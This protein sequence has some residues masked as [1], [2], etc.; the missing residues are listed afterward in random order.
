[1]IKVPTTRDNLSALFNQTTNLY[2]YRRFPDFKAVYQFIFTEENCN[3]YY[4][5]KFAEGKAEYQEGTYES[6]SITIY[7]PVYVWYDICNGRLNGV[8]GWFTRK[9]R[10][11]GSFY[12][13]KILNKLLGKKFTSEDIQGIEDKIAGFEMNNGKGW[14]KPDKILI[15]NGSPRKKDGFTF[16][17]LQYLI[18]GIRKAGVSVETV[19]IYDN[20]LQIEPC[21]GCFSC[22]VKTKGN[23]I[24]KDDANELVQKIKDSYLTIFAFPL[25]IDSMPGKLKLLM[26]RLF[27][28]VKPV[29]V[30]YKKLTRH[31]LWSCQENYFALFCI[32]GFPEIEHFGPIIE[33]FK[34]V[35]R[36]S[37]RPLIASILRPGAEF[38][39]SAPYCKTI[40]G[41]I[42]SAIEQAGKELAVR[43]RVSKV[44]LKTISDSFNIPKKTWR[45][46][47]NLNWLL[48]SKEGELNE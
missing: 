6:P 45:L 38:L 10:I 46:G 21:R 42:L 41:K 2:D 16:L 39:V 22:W 15:I 14:K 47:A 17:Y 35:A 30:P 29:F 31:P 23:C 9:Y 12:Y 19:D 37:H 3:Y 44:L 32:N 20:K 33:T 48:K 1:M 28:M 36:N 7:A 4:Y 11:K 13:L 27:V 34:G 40:L 25:Y 8:W 24:I 5:L 18:K 26:D 43:G